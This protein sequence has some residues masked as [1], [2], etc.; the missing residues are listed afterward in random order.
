MLEADFV[1]RFAG[2]D[3]TYL[4]YASIITTVLPLIRNAAMNETIRP[5][6]PDE[7][8]AHFYEHLGNIKKEMKIP[9][10]TKN[11]LGAPL[12]ETLLSLSG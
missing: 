9:E 1:A 4:D 3:Q 10:I 6:H 8:S 5:T 11:A 7:Y 12:C 2:L